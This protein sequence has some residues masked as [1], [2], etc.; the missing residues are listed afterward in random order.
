MSKV[1]VHHKEQN[2]V[3]VHPEKTQVDVQYQTQWG[4]IGG[5]LS[6]QTDLQTKLDEIQD[7]AYAGL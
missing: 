1:V 5:V 6:N 4:K 2:E 3:H 7:I